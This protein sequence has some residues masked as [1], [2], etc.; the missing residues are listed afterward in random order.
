MCLAFFEQV[1]PSSMIP[2]CDFT[3]DVILNVHV[4]SGN[5]S[6][7]ALAFLGRERREQPEVAG[8]VQDWAETG[9]LQPPGDVLVPPVCGLHVARPLLHPVWSVLRHG[10][11]LPDNGAHCG[12]G[13]H[14]HRHHRGQRLTCEFKFLWFIL[15]HDEAKRIRIK[16]MNERGLFDIIIFI[17]VQDKFIFKHLFASLK[18]S[19]LL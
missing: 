13:S 2:F 17:L 15:I 16:Y 1:S 12:L 7:G 3:I 5:A 9:A 11:R 18:L 10:L 19:P 6:P 4:L 8:A 14:A